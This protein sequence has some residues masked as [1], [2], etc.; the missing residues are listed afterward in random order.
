MSIDIFWQ[1]I[2]GSNG[3]TITHERVCYAD[4]GRFIESGKTGIEALGNL[5]DKI[6]EASFEVSKKIEEP[7]KMIGNK[8]KEK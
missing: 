1:D 5:W 4:C 2:S 8:D 7:D 3:K 6:R